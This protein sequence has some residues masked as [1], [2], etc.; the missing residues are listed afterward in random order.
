MTTILFVERGDDC[1]SEAWTKE[2]Q[3]NINHLS[4]TEVFQ[5]EHIIAYKAACFRSLD[6]NTKGC[7]SEFY[8]SNCNVSL[9]HIKSLNVDHIN[10]FRRNMEK[11]L[12]TRGPITLESVQKVQNFVS[13]LMALLTQMWA[14]SGLKLL[15][16]TSTCQPKQ[17]R[18][19][20]TWFTSKNSYSADNRSTAK[21]MNRI[22]GTQYIFSSSYQ[23]EVLDTSFD[24]HHPGRDLSNEDRSG[25]DVQRVV[26]ESQPCGGLLQ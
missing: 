24:P 8:L 7:Y 16:D 2:E 11:I 13:F 22:G 3:K 21:T 20:A 23:S 1:Y 9:R 19:H 14:P 15:N 26:K 18:I 17:I 10:C 12:R 6:D 25:K 4:K 5:R